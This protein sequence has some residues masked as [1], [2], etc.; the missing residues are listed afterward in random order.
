VDASCSF[1][2]ILLSSQLQL[3][4]VMTSYGRRLFF[5]TSL[6]LLTMTTWPPTSHPGM[7]SVVPFSAGL[8]YLSSSC[9]HVKVCEITFLPVILPPVVFPKAV[10]S[11]LYYSLCTPLLSILSISSCSPNHHLYANDTRLFLSFHPTDFESKVT[12]HSRL[13]MLVAVLLLF[14]RHLSYSS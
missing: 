12:C 5:L 1:I 14:F 3:Q 8:S 2:V 11:V 7:A 4:Q 9:F 10:F 13:W 6:T